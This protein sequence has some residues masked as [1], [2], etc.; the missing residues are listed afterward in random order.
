MPKPR[1]VDRDLGYAEIMKRAKSIK[2]SYVRVGVVGKK[3]DESDGTA[4]VAE[5]AIA[6][7]L[8]TDTIPARSFLRSTFDAKQAELKRIGAQLIDKVMTGKMPIKQAL[9]VIGS[10]LS[11]EVK[12]TITVGPG[13]P[14]PNAPSTAA[15]K[16]AKG[17]GAIRTL[18]DTGRML[19]AIA[20][21]AVV[22][23]KVSV[24]GGNL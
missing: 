5:Y 11:A 23:G 20:W 1:V 15:R 21:E 22:N 8:G 16:Q 17:K 10:F 13:V 3:A 7:E 6:N 9:N 19:G 12:K 18:V 14:P 2:E 24:E 4:T